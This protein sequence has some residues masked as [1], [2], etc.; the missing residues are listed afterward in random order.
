MKYCTLEDTFLKQFSARIAVTIPRPHH[1]SLLEVINNTLSSYNFRFVFT[2]EG[3]HRSGGVIRADGRRVTKDVESWA[4]TE[5][6]A[7]EEDMGRFLEC[8]AKDELLVTRLLGKI[9]YFVASYG[10]KPM[11]FLQLEVEE[12]QEVTDRHLIDPEKVPTN[13]SELI[14]PTAPHT[15]P[16][17]TVSR[18]YYRFRRLID[19]R[20]IIAYLSKFDEPT[21]S[22]QRFLGEWA[23]SY[24]GTTH[25]FCHHWII[26]L[27]EH[28]DRNGQLRLTTLP[29]SLGHRRL[30]Y[31]HWDIHA[32][33]VNLANQLDTFDRAAGYPF[34]WYFHWVTG[35]S[36]P[37]QILS[38]VQQDLKKG[39]QYLGEPN[40]EILETWFK[41]PYKIS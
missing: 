39:C 21:T 31:F 12:L 27:H 22:L 2:Q 9:H 40:K 34:A 23:K 5:L 17:Q 19:M 20:V 37:S 7:F 11:D 6:Q 41:E 36:I 24:T 10:T 29:L 25:H 3:W 28:L 38:S 1:T 18:A 14:E 32:Q 26:N 13:F 4:K 8:Y 33:G 35:I 30:R 16:F 15:L